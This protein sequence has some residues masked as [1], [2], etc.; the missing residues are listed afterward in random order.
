M[1]RI[2]VFALM[3]CISVLSK[4][5][6]LE[7]ENIYE[8]S[9][10]ANRGY[11]GDVTIDEPGNDIALTFVTKSNDKMAKFETY[12]FD[13]TTYAF[14]KIETDEIEFEK[15]R[16][17]YKWFKYRGDDY[18][19]EAVS[20][21]RNF[22]GTLVLKR[23][24]ITYNWSWFYGG[25]DRD[26][27]LLEKVKPKND[28]GNKYYAW[29]S[30]ENDETGD[31]LVLVGPKAK[32]AKDED[33]NAK[34]KN[35]SVLTITKDLDIAKETKIDFEHPMI[36]MVSQLVYNP[37]EDDEEETDLSSSDWGLV[38]VPAGGSGLNKVADPEMNNFTFT[39][40]NAANELKQRIN[41]KP[42]YNLW[43]IQEIVSAGNELYF[44]GPAKKD[45]NYFNEIFPPSMDEDTRSA[46]IE[47]MKWQA[48]Q[49]MKVS[50]GKVDYLK[51][52]SIDEFDA[53]LKTPPSQKKSPSYDGK[54]FAMVNFV[55]ANN[56]DILIMG[57]NFNKSK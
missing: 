27:K 47:T 41:F 10:K 37:D 4:A 33:P 15:A 16:N 18:S 11:L 44:I 2:L 25:Y 35:F 42:E 17:K 40:I 50:D 1:K 5:Q 6:S 21:E 32:M 46:T 53:K 51:A 39:R 34:M 31:V 57:Q 24:L 30:A 52:T 54:K 12:H 43:G 49:V 28:E 8:I 45:N 3:L 23:K 56:G 14:K 38:F 29:T 19:V 55:K 48:F 26:V 13:A 36:P 9:G 7:A 22:T 20:V